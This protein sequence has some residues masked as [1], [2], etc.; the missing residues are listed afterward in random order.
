MKLVVLWDFPESTFDLK[1]GD[2]ILSF[3]DPELENNLIKE[4]SSKYKFYLARDIGLEIKKSTTDLYQSIIT[5]LAIQPIRNGKNLRELLF[6]DEIQ[7]SEWF[8]NPLSFRDC[9]A[10][11]LY[12]NILVINII[13][14]VKKITEIDQVVLFGEPMEISVLFKYN[15]QGTSNFKLNPK[16]VIRA[17]LKSFFQ[18]ALVF[19]ISTYYFIL[20]KLYYRNKKQYSDIVKVALS[21]FYDW[22]FNLDDNLKIKDH[23]YFKDLVGN[24]SEKGI[25]YIY[26]CWFEPNTIPSSKFKLRDLIKVAR[27]DK[28]LSLINNDLHFV[29]IFTSYCNS[30]RIYFKVFE[31]LNNFYRKNDFEFNGYNLI[32]LLSK[33]LFSSLLSFEVLKYNLIYKAFKRHFDKNKSL[34]VFLSFLEHYPFTRALC[35]ASNNKLDVI[36]MQHASYSH[37]KTFYY[38]DPRHEFESSVIDG[39]ILPHPNQIITMGNRNKALFE[40]VGYKSDNVLQY[41]SLRYK[42]KSEILNSHTKLMANDSFNILLPLSIKESIHVDLIKAVYTAI[43]GIL[44]VRVIIRNHPYHDV[45]DNIWV[46]TNL[47]LENIRFSE[48]TLLDD[49]NNSDLIISSYST[50][51]EEG[52]LMGIPV[53]QW[54]SLDFEGSPLFCDPRVSTVSNVI[55]LH[56]VIKDVFLNYEHYKPSSSTIDEIYA[57]YFSPSHNSS[58]LIS[59]YI[60]SRI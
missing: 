7:S 3:C 2:V 10:S 51:A 31:I 24:F 27:G 57:D 56:N 17:L 48:N 15:K 6:N 45:R 53:I 41:G 37:G 43:K 8:F 60:E 22:S 19:F 13:S 42:D 47:N 49:L 34:K 35:L 21:G 11:D 25:N 44:N 28:N 9:E 55:E 59:N 29:D 46:M 16:V 14:H 36:S 38:L 12:K 54:A 23:K 39:L 52:L 50:V 5:K 18:N 40:S 32:P 4:F 33:E 1:V 58:T 20:F 26:L 30:F